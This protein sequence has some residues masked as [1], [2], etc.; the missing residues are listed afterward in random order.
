MRAASAKLI[1]LLDL[2]A[3]LGGKAV[4]LDE[5]DMVD[6]LNRT[7][8]AEVPKPLASLREKQVRFNNVCS[9]EDMSEMVFKLLEL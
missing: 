6:E 2:T 9:K 4:Q 5:F 7:T 8:G 3:V 1:A